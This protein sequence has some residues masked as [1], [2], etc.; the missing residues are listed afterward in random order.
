MKRFSKH[1]RYPLWLVVIMLTVWWAFFGHKYQFIYNHGISMQ[2]T[3]LDGEWIVI[4]KRSGLPKNWKPDRLDVVVI[5]DK[6]SEDW[7]C[8]RVIGL[9]GDTIEIKKGIIYLNNKKF[10]GPYGRGKIL[11][12]LV[13]EDDNNL[14]YWEDG[15]MG[16]KAGEPVVELTDQK[17][18]KISEGYV[19]VI[20]DN[21]E[22]SWFGDLPLEEIKGL[23][24]F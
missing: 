12:Y 7:L 21:R 14:K 22:V 9:P 19:W 16:E 6:K 2:P 8:K 24:V 18:K 3:H 5:F 11:I 20:G 1:W 13:D 15:P 4:E 17:L 10:K 23:V